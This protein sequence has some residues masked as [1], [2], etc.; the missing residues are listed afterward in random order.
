MGAV[1]M[2]DDDVFGSPQAAATPAA[3]AEMSDSDVF[4]SAPSPQAAMPQPT[5]AAPTAIDQLKATATDLSETPEQKAALRQQSQA[6]YEQA[7]ANANQDKDWHQ[8]FRE[9]MVRGAKQGALGL[10]QLESA[11]EGALGIQQNPDIQQAMAD[12]AKQ[13]QTEGKGAGIAGTAGEL[14]TPVNAALTSMT[15]NPLTQGLAGRA[16]TGAVMGAMQPVTETG[17]EGDS[18]RAGNAAAAG[19]TNAALPPVVSGLTKGAGWLAQGLANKTGLTDWAANIAEKLGDK[20]TT[21]D[22]YQAAK[23]TGF[24]TSGKSPKEIAANL[25]AWLSANHEGMAQSIS[26]KSFDPIDANVG[27]SKQYGKALDTAGELYNSARQLGADDVVPAKGLEDDISGLINNIASKPLKTSKENGAL[28]RLTALRDSLSNNTKTAPGYNAAADA[29][30][31]TDIPNAV[32]VNT[33]IDLKQIANQYFDKSEPDPLFSKVFSVAKNGLKQ[34]SEQNPEF[35]DALAKADSYWGD[36]VAP[37]YTDNK[38]LDKFWNTDDFHDAKALANNGK[39]LPLELQKRASEWLDKIKSPQEL[40][41]LTNALPDEQAGALRAAAFG[42]IMDKMGFDAGSIA[43]PKRFALMQKAAE[44]KPQVLENLDN[45]KTVLADMNL[46]GLDNSMPKNVAQEQLEGN[47]SAKEALK[48]LWSATVGKRMY[49]VSH[50]AK[51]AAGVEGATAE[52]L[53]SFQKNI[54]KGSPLKKSIQNTA[55]GLAPKVGSAAGLLAAKNA[56]E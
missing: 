31:G 38:L 15:G 14:V 22:I 32:P 12:V 47:K 41:S 40:E 37:T 54:V 2:T 36:K 1:E 42:K 20:P 7:M 17:D 19:V 6:G 46:R 24:D 48:S 30:L 10:G 5:Q 8:R 34:A 18:Q 43:D 44:G 52:A 49:A 4:G 23:A 25:Q 56:T 39:P 16:A 28:S 26:G 9:G 13:Y 50:A 33:L 55:K 45:M 3:Q 51:A 53:K 11:A 35:G 29:Y 21:S 27:I